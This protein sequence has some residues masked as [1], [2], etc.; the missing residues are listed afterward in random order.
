MALLSRIDCAIAQ[1]SGKPMSWRAR[2]IVSA[3]VSAT[4]SPAERA[5]LAPAIR[6]KRQ[7]RVEVPAAPKARQAEG[8]DG[9]RRRAKLGRHLAE[10][11]LSLLN[12]LQ[13]DDEAVRRLAT[14]AQEKIAPAHN[15]RNAAL[16]A[17]IRSTVPNFTF[18]FGALVFV[19]CSLRSILSVRQSFSTE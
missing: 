18:F 1:A 4:E 7:L 3:C 14:E 8:R 13:D 5:V 17:R 2:M 15:H 9:R 12:A 11:V 19:F 10:A 6:H 16:I